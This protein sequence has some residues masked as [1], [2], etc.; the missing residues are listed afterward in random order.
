MYTFWPS[1]SISHYYFCSGATRNR[2]L[3]P[4]PSETKLCI[5]D[6]LS[7]WTRGSH[8]RGPGKGT[9]PSHWRVTLSVP[10]PS[11]ENGEGCTA[12]QAVLNLCQNQYV[13]GVGNR[14]W[15]Q[16]PHFWVWSKIL[17]MSVFPWGKVGMTFFPVCNYS[18]Y[19]FPRQ[20]KFHSCL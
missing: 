16:L 2:Q 15:W 8:H 1:K 17:K 13:G 19:S 10:V 9:N 5:V 18:N 4:T 14:W 11:L 7:W 3:H 12:V 20:M 6:K